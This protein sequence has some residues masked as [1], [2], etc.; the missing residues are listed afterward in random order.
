MFSP[1]FCKADVGWS[2]HQGLSAQRDYALFI[3]FIYVGVHSKYTEEKTTGVLT[4]REYCCMLKVQCLTLDVIPEPL[5]VT[6]TGTALPVELTLQPGN[7]LDFENC[8]VDCCSCKEFH[9][10]NDSASLPLEFCCHQQAHYKCSPM[11][12][13]VNPG[14]KFTLTVL[15]QPRQLGCLD[16]SLVI[17]VLGPYVLPQQKDKNK[18]VVHTETV[19]LKGTGISKRIEHSPSKKIAMAQVNDLATSIRPHDTRKMIRYAC[20]TYSIESS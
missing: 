20:S 4:L 9:L 8:I 16:S 10:C 17:D 2:H 7:V 13:K 14:E 18:I 3:K 1:E 19:E 15:F 5:E 6:F 11:R 12:G